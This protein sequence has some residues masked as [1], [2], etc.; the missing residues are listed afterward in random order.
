MSSTT[1][2]HLPTK[3]C[4]LSALCA[5]AL[6]LTRGGEGDRERLSRAGWGVIGGNEVFMRR[7]THVQALVA[8]VMRVDRAHGLWGCSRGLGGARC[9]QHTLKS[10]VGGGERLP[11]GHMG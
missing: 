1:G 3:I 4:A 7:A 6:A 2:H 11:A 9:G 10:A 8:C 5:Q